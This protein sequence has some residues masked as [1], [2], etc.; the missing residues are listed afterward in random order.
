VVAVNAGP[1]ISRCGK[2][3]IKE[4]VKK[5]RISSDTAR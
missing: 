4:S 1:F 3:P 2:L 5:I